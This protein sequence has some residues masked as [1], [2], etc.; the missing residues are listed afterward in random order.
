MKK[1]NFLKFKIND[2]ENL[3]ILSIEETYNTESR[4]LLSRHSCRIIR[5]TSVVRVQIHVVPEH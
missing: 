3:Y 1:I 4:T 5:N 2:K